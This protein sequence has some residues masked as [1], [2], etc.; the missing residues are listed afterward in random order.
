MSRANIT[1]QQIKI[2]R[3]LYKIVKNKAMICDVLGIRQN[4]LAK[5][6]D[7]PYTDPID[8]DLIA[9]SLSE[10]LKIKALKSAFSG[11]PKTQLIRTFRDLANDLTKDKYKSSNIDNLLNQDE[12]ERLAE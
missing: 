2:A 6:L 7:R 12:L 11:K 3:M 8:W 5:H 10:L 9:P 4:A 1:N